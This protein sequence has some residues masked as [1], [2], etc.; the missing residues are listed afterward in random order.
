MKYLL[1]A[2]V[3]YLAWRWFTASRQSS[4]KASVAKDASAKSGADSAAEAMIKC[5]HCGIHLPQ[6]EAIHGPGEVAFCSKEHEAAHH[7]R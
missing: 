3:I 5:A 2:L 1:W 7:H 4:S 6:S